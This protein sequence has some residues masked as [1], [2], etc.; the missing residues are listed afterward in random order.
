MKSN[1]LLELEAFGHSIWMDFI[2]RGTTSS[3]KLQF[4][5]HRLITLPI[6]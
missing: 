4:L 6:A 3:R 1:P 2:S 5:P